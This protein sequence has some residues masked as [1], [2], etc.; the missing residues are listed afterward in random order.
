MPIS[1]GILIYK[2]QEDAIYFLLAHP[3]GPYYKNKDIGTWGIPKGLV[4][5]G[6]EPLAAAQREFLEE[7]NLVLPPNH[8]ME[9]PPVQYKNGKHLLSWALEVKELSLDNFKSNTFETIWPPKSGEMA[10]F[11]EIDA[12]SFFELTK[13]KEKIHPVQLPLI[14]CIEH[15]K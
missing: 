12:L 5:E 2:K 10:T 8:F 7:T 3:G 4:E 13:A 15:L 11:D 6:E 9:L 14:E 1:A